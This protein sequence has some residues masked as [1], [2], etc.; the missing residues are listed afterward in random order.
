MPSIAFLGFDDPIAGVFAD[1]DFGERHLLFFPTVGSL[2]AAW[3]SGELNLAAIIGK[4]EIIGYTALTLAEEVRE[5]R[6]PFVPVFLVAERIDANLRL[7]ALNNGVADMFRLPFEA[8]RVVKRIEFIVKNWRQLNMGGQMHTPQIRKTGFGKRVFDVVFAAFLLLM[9]SPLFLLVYLLVRIE[10][11]GPAF[12]YSLRVGSGY[13]IFKFF[14]FRSMYTDAEKR[15]KELQH[16][17]Q[18]GA[19]VGGQSTPDQT[20]QKNCCDCSLADNCPHAMFAD[21]AWHCEKDFDTAMPK[22]TAFFKLKNDPRVTRVGKFIRNTSIDELPQLWNVLI[23][24][25]S[26]V[27]N[28]PLP[29]YE[30][31]KLTTDEYALRFL[32]PAGITG[33]WQVEKRGKGEMDEHERL[34]LDNAYAL[35]FSLAGDIKLIL[36]TI[37]ALFQKANV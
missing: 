13:R 20:T 17:N 4:S 25:M 1:C 12:Y 6:L 32:A 23:G 10:S 14:K 22:K 29:L 28:R 21:G 18:Y 33:L 24:D 37:P 16:L 2:C 36:R 19:T 26:I 34:M 11:K 15:V 31:E 27:G 8:S 5:R 30:A 3:K 7:I 9:L 35:K